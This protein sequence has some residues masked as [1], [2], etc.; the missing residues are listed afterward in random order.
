MVGNYHRMTAKKFTVTN[1]SF[2]IS[3]E[4]IG[5]NK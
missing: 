4:I 1:N 2:L 5:E 3:I